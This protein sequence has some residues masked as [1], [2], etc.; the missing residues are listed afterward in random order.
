MKRTL[1][2][3]E[4]EDHCQY[5]GGWKEFKTEVDNKPCLIK[6]VGWV[7]QENAKCITMVSCIDTQ[8]HSVGKGVFTVIKSCIKKRRRITI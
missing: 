1:L 4:W 6:S 7:I 5:A 8:S 3:I 2:Y